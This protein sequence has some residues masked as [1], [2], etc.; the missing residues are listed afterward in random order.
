MVAAVQVPCTSVARA[1]LESRIRVKNPTVE[2]RAHFRSLVLIRLIVLYL[3]ANRVSA[4]SSGINN[5]PTIGTTNERPHSLARR[6]SDRR[7]VT[8]PLVLE[9]RTEA[10]Y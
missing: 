5:T 1:E 3:S 4:G 7:K 9:R 2:S 6:Y 8:L 10:L